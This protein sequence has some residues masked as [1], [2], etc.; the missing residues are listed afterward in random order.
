MKSSF[1]RS[2]VR[3]LKTRVY[4]SLSLLVYDIV[5]IL[6]LELQR[7]GPASQSRVQGVKLVVRVG[8]QLGDGLLKVVIFYVPECSS[9][10]SRLGGFKSQVTLSSTCRKRISP[11]DMGIQYAMKKVRAHRG[12]GR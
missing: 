10:G 11:N 7:W 9:R 3:Q 6:S 8:M 12:C 4:I 1:G 2:P 5:A